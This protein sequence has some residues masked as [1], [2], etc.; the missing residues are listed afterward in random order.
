MGAQRRTRTVLQFTAQNFP[1]HT[2]SEE[3]ASWDERQSQNME[4]QAAKNHEHIPGIGNAAGCPGE[5]LLWQP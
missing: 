4:E 1:K 2:G 3:M 5:A